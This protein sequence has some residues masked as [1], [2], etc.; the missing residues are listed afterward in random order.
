MS[1]EQASQRATTMAGHHDANTSAKDISFSKSRD[2][3]IEAPTLARDAKISGLTPV[4]ATEVEISQLV[5]DNEAPVYLTGARF[6]LITISQVHPN[7]DSIRISFVSDK[8]AD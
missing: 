8:F 7:P 1:N 3:P 5:P 4:G 2:A 6:W